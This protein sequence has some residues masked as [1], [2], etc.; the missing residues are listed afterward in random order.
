[1]RY[2]TIILLRI[3]LD[4]RVWK[5]FQKLFKTRAAVV[6][7]GFKS[8][9]NELRRSSANGDVFKTVSAVNLSLLF[10][11]SQLLSIRHYGPTA[12]KHLPTGLPQ[13]MC[14]RKINKNPL[15]AFALYVVF[16]V[17][18]RSLLRFEL[19]VNLVSLD[20]ICKSSLTP[21]CATALWCT[22]LR[23]Y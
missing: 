5:I 1:V 2:V 7:F 16:I 6:Y 18:G 17:I 15:T 4:P 21:N 12:S 22:T 20:T 10:Q 14:T 11:E 23:Y 3:L 13:I 9:N 19:S 8:K